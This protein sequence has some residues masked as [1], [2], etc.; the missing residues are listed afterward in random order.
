MSE[1]EQDV[2][3]GTVVVVSPTPIASPTSS[4]PNSSKA[5]VP[6]LS[7]PRALANNFM[8]M[9]G[10]SASTKSG[11]KGGSVKFDTNLYQKEEDMDEKDDFQASR[12]S[13]KELRDA[14]SRQPSYRESTIIDSSNGKD[15]IKVMTMKEPEFDE[16]QENPSATSTRQN[17]GGT[18][19]G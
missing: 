14:F 13:A 9:A 12:S 19:V 2:E 11:R 7:M 4:A 17:S 15:T 8:A 6:P 18:I 10:A 5:A 3:M 16:Q 1:D